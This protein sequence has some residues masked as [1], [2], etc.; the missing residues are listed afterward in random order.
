MEDLAIELLARGLSVRD[1]EEAFKD[2]R[3]AVAVEDGSLE[4]GARLRADYQEFCRRDLGE[5]EIIYLLRR[6]HCRAHPAGAEAL[7]VLAAWGIATDGKKV[8]LG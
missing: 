5:H 7:S 6:R 2:E 8:L 4:I 3:P 1:I